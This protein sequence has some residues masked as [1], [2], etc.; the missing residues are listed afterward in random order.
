MTSTGKVR[1]RG[2]V[3]DKVHVDMYFKEI[4]KKEDTLMMQALRRQFDSSNNG[5]MRAM[6]SN[7]LMSSMGRN[8]NESQSFRDTMTMSAKLNHSLVDG[9][10]HTMLIRG[11][12]P[13][14]IPAKYNS[15]PD[16]RDWNK[17]E[18]RYREL[19]EEMRNVDADIEEKQ[20]EIAIDQ[21]LIGGAA[22]DSLKPKSGSHLL[23][24]AFKWRD[25]GTANSSTYVWHKSKLSP[26]KNPSDAV[27]VQNSANQYGFSTKSC[28]LPEG[29]ILINP[30][31]EK[32][33]KGTLAPP[34]GATK[35][36]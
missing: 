11:S 2:Q 1:P 5:V 15:F 12:L 28:D 13:S 17:A 23:G 16:D 20:R 36:K 8:G 21:K 25:E 31:A 30:K 18:R 34:R 10:D 32:R 7:N 26:V 29:N 33:F 14:S 4:S 24:S 3:H 35:R 22:L 27:G 19:E 6:T 9:G